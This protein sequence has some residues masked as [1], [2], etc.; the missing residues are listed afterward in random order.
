MTPIY[1]SNDLLYNTEELTFLTDL[2]PTELTWDEHRANADDM[3]VLY[4][5]NIEFA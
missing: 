3:A 5:K 1:H 4:N 2:A